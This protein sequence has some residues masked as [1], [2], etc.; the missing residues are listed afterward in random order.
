MVPMIKL[1]SLENK[2]FL[3]QRAANFQKQEFS[4]DLI[5]VLVK[6]TLAATRVEIDF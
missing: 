1:A 6:L 4:Q 2:D 3:D 5:D